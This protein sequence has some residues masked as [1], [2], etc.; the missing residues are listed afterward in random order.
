[1]GV[2]GLRTWVKKLKFAVSKE[3]RERLKQNAKLL[4]IVIKK[5]NPDGSVTVWAPQWLKASR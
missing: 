3:R 2:P 1:M 4:K 5:T